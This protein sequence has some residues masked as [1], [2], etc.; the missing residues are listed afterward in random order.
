MNKTFAKRRKYEY[1]N[2]KGEFKMNSVN[3]IGRLTKNPEIRTFGKGRESVNMCRF[4]LAVRDGKDKDGNERTQFIS[5]AAWGA[6]CDILEQY[7]YKGDML[8]V[9][10][11][12]VNNNY[13]KDGQTV[14]QSEVRISNI[15]L[16]PNPSNDDSGKGKT[17]R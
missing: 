7:T 14:Y 10:G 13:E 8:G 5:C 9:D 3:L 17:R 16:L 4:T 11:K 12:I 1:N 6:V 15:Y 2:L